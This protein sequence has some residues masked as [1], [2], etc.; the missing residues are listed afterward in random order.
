MASQRRADPA[1]EGRSEPRAPSQ[2]PLDA[3][4][5]GRML[6][7]VARRIERDWNAHLDAWELNHASLPVLYILA[8]GPHS[9]RDLARAC[10][11][12]EQTMSRILARLERSGYVS[13]RTHEHDRRRHAVDITPA[14]RRAL[15]EASDRDVA[16]EMSVRGLG[17]EQ[18][19]HLRAL[20]RAML[21]ADRPDG[22]R[23]DRVAP[24]PEG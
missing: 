4:P 6:S 19:M 15:V 11:V 18:V 2:Q 21:A 22:D 8:A 7:A 3:W 14:G 1:R 9:Q 23:G 20:L 16:E 5:T 13:R 10:A 17:P 12:T 24:L